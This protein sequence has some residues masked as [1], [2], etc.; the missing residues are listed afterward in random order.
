MQD[1]IKPMLPAELSRPFDNDEWLFEENLGGLR[2]ITVK[3]EGIVNI[4][5]GKNQLL[6]NDFPELV[7][8]LN[9]FPSDFVLDGEI[10]VSQT[11]VNLNFETLLKYQDFTELPVR[12]IV[13]DLLAVKEQPLLRTPLIKRKEFLRKVLPSTARLVQLKSFVVGNGCD[14]YNSA[15]K[16]NIEGITAK[17]AD[18]IYRPGKVSSEWLKIRVRKTQEIHLHELIQPLIFHKQIGSVIAEQTEIKQAHD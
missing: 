16:E 8:E 7:K 1:Y 14:L 2:A 15:V 4:Y 17:K 5:A 11:Y 13:F 12:Y 3:S 18:G 9:K 6:N 10:V